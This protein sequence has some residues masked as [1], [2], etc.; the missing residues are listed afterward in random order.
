[1]V[2]LNGTNYHLWK[3][4]MKDLL[5]VKKLHLPVFATQKPDSMFEEN[6]DFDKMVQDCIEQTT[7]IVINNDYKNVENLF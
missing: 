6:W 7:F 1:M 3:G 4:K 5:F 2:A